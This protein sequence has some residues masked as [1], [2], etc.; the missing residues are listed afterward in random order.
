MVVG[1]AL[2]PEHQP[3]QEL[4]L[5]SIPGADIF[6]WLRFF[7]FSVDQTIVFNVLDSLHDEQSEVG[8]G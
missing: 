6:D 4:V 7:I 8:Q 2:K 3:V 5:G 1:V